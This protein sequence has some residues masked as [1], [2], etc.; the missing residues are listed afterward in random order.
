[1]NA[2]IGI[3]VNP[4]SGR[5]V[6]RLA[7]RATNMTHE[8]KRDLVARAAA[9]ADA[10]GATDLFVLEEP[11]RIASLALAHMPLR[12]RSHVLPHRARNDAGDTEI[13]VARFLEAGCTTLISLGGD[14]SNRAIVR[15]LHE[16]KRSDV[17]L[18]PL[19]TGTNNVFP[20]LAEPTIAG[21]VAALQARGLLADDLAQRAKVLHLRLGSPPRV[22]RDLGLIDAVLLR[23]DHV[24]NLLPFDANRLARLFL[25]RAEPD[26]I[27]TSPIG[28]L[29]DPVGAEDDAGLLVEMGPGRRFAAPLSPGLFKE[30]AVRRATR[31][32]FG[33]SVP[34]RGAGVLALDG[35]RDHR[36][37]EGEL[38]T[39]TLRRDGPWVLDIGRAMRW[40]VA[41]GIMPPVPIEAASA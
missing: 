24:G 30:V 15:A 1:M 17:H 28:G 18:I 32:A 7:A 35:D 9:G 29:I 34:F 38:A 16:L 5:D 31:V 14:G 19:S 6:R 11:F 10:A 39:V 3:C 8:A 25:S 26:A 36:L 27:G 12:A 20:V 4:M 2:P 21:M 40:A 41:A 37:R 33:V 23:N 22:K 13:A